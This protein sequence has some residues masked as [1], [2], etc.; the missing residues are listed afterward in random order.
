M[1]SEKTRLRSTRPC[2][3]SS[4]H[5]TVSIT[6]FLYICICGLDWQG[7]MLEFSKDLANNT[8]SEK[9]GRYDKQ[10]CRLCV[11]MCIQQFILTFLLEMFGIKSA[12]WREELYQISSLVSFRYF[13]KQ[14]K[15]WELWLFFFHRCI[16]MFSEAMTSSFL[17]EM[18]QKSFY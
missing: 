13:I 8:V 4:E 16:P 7:I 14:H 9:D 2:N 5:N 15:F 17:N 6:L 1:V 18:M 11:H 3:L 12:F 10:T